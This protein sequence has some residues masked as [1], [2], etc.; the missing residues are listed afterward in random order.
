M[1]RNRLLTAYLEPDLEDEA[2][3]LLGRA[4]KCLEAAGRTVEAGFAYQRLIKRNPDSTEANRA[5]VERPLL[6]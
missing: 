5:R 3:F 6:E 2:R 1:P 4:G